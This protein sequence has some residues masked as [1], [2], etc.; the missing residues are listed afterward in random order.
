[1]VIFGQM[2]VNSM[3]LAVYLSLFMSTSAQACS[4]DETRCFTRDIGVAINPLS[5]TGIAELVAPGAEGY[6]I[7]SGSVSK[8]YYARGEELVIPFVVSGT[9]KDSD[10]EHDA[11][12]NY[13]DIEYR[14]YFNKKLKGIY[15]DVFSRIGQINGYGE[16]TGNKDGGYSRI[17][18]ENR[19]IGAGVGIGYNFLAG[20]SRLYWGVGFKYGVYLFKD[21]SQE[22]VE[23]DV[24]LNV[25]VAHLNHFGDGEEYFIDFEFLR[26]GVRF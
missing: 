25:P 7:F 8:I 2:T 14:K 9:L 20:N 16:A 24:S 21:I 6:S 10:S 4:R 12:A 22:T 3:L 15:I 17:Y 19:F 13:M 26:I 18:K 11:M 1:M 23:S 5:F